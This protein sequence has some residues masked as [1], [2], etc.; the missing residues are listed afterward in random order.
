MSEKQHAA[1]S[2]DRADADVPRTIEEGQATSAEGDKGTERSAT[3]REVFG[4]RQFRA[5]YSASMLSWV[6]DYLARAAVTALVY[7]RTHSAWISAAA[8]AISYLPWV[9]GGPLLA[10]VAE[11]Y[12]YRRVMVTSDL[13]RAATI[14]VV[15]IPGMPVPA[16]LLLLFATAMINPPFEAARSALLPRLLEGDKYIQA[17]VVQNVTG[18]A[19][20]LAGYLVGASIAAYHPHLALLIDAGTFACSAALVGLFVAEYQPGLARSQRTHLVRETGEGFNLVFGNDVLRAIAILIFTL[21]LFPTVPEGLAAAWANRLADTPAQAGFDQGLIMAAYPAGFILGGLVIG[22]ALPPPLRRRLVR[23]LAVL[24]PLSLV[25]ALLNPPATMV[26]LLAMACGFMV[27]GLFPTA[28]GMFVRALP[29]AFRA[30]AFGIM[31]GGVQIL[32]GLS[33]FACGALATRFA[34]PRVV[35]LWSIAGVALML[36]AGVWWPSEGRF[37]AAYR[38]A[39]AANGKPALTAGNADG[40]TTPAAEAAPEHEGT[41]PRMRAV[42]SV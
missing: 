12:P 30:R 8:F 1:A 29:N 21:M 4:S 9:L 34:L 40:E 2:G 31:Q 10:A 18:Q 7:Q 17:M 28:N 25:P 23:P 15:A 16:M 33:V 24:A 39:D 11:R 5:L 19:A 41:P 36:A 26:A 20:Q 13:V 32:Q 14:A 22:R 37:S 42:E 38:A 35:G 3:F 27:S 6:G